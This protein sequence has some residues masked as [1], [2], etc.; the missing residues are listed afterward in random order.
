[1]ETS[2]VACDLGAERGRVTL[3]TLHQGRLRLSEIHHFPNTPTPDGDT[4]HWDIA[5]LYQ[6]LVDG[7]AEVGR[8]DQAVHGVSCSSWGHDY[9]LFDSGGSLM[10]P[11]HV[12]PTPRAQAGL[13]D[14]LSRI[15]WE[16]I[17][18]ETGGQPTAQSTLFQ[19]GVEKS[20]RLSKADRLL[21][22]ADG[23]NYLLSGEARVEASLA[24]TTQLFNPLLGNWSQRL[25]GALRLPK[26]ILPPIV[27]AGTVLGPLRQDLASQTKLEDVEV[28]SSCSHELASALVGLPAVNDGNWAFLS[29][30]SWSAMG[31]ELSQPL[32]NDAARDLGFTCETGF[33]GTNRFMKKTAGLWI[34]EE[35]LRHWSGTEHDLGESVLMHLAAQSA[36]FAALINPVDARFLTPGDMPD[37]I[38]A[39]CKETGQAAPRK[40]GPILRCVLESVALYYRKTLREIEDVTGK[41][42][43]RLYMLAGGNFNVLFNSFITNALQIPVVVVPPETTAIGNIMTQAIA[44]GHVPT[45]EMARQMIADSYRYETLQPHAAVWNTA[46]DRLARLT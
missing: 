6:Q 15:P 21:P 23:F 44:L 27:S 1:M 45:L 12:Q 20:R 7:L 35:C 24:S 10:S 16:T 8:A 36:P 3:G 33:A 41:R 42:I 22:V 46:F 4:L 28:I 37:K 25:L 18:E 11:T 9:L 13:N 19:L 34:V 14:L 39:F 31:V 26:H 5:G 43:N 32:I 17:Y 2:Y 40:P 29:P 38:K 30:G